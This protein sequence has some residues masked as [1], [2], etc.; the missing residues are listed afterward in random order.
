MLKLSTLVLY[1]TL[2]ASAVASFDEC[3][4]MRGRYFCPGVVGS[5]QDMT[6]II[7]EARA[8]GRVTYYYLYEQ[9]GEEAFELRFMASDQGTQN[10]DHGGMI[11]KCEN[12]FY[13][14]SSNGRASDKTLLNFVNDDGD[15]EVIR[16]GDRKRFLLCNRTR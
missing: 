2:T 14:N 10:P 3:P 16:N 11:G 12:G 15:Y 13:Y 1:L 7:T 8:S 9:R 5:H 6:M 4:K